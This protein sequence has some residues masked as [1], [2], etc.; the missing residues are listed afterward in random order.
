[1]KNTVSN[2]RNFTAKICVMAEKKIEKKSYVVLQDALFEKDGSGAYKPK[3]MAKEGMTTLKKHSTK[4]VVMCINSSVEDITSLLKNNDIPFDKVIKAEEDFDFFIMGDERSIKTWS[5]ESALSDIGYKL[6][7]DP[8][9]KPNM[10]E[11]ADNSLESFF[12]KE[13]ERCQ[14]IK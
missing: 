11:K 4:L 5:W 12:R 8:D 2:T 3:V 14:R 6:S 9:N 13:N 1:M 7:H 10:Q